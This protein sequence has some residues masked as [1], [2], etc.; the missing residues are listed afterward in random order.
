MNVETTCWKINSNLERKSNVETMCIAQRIY[1]RVYKACADN[2]EIENVIFR[3]GKINEIDSLETT[4][5]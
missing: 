1:S 3:C 5:K 2:D 4:C